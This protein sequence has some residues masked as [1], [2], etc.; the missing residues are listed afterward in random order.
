[1]SNSDKNQADQIKELK[2]QNEILIRD[3]VDSNVNILIFIFVIL[4]VV[5]G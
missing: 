3:N 2:L 4:V 5:F 1:M